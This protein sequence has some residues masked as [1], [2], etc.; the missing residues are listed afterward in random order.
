VV[1]CAAEA[2]Y[3]ALCKK[4][5]NPALVARRA[6]AEDQQD[7]LI[8]FPPGKETA[9]HSAYLVK[10]LEWTATMRL[11]LSMREAATADRQ[12]CIPVIGKTAAAP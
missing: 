1:E 5:L 2:I 11:P 12:V 10:L 7:R 8:A 3:G 9:G 4:N 6:N